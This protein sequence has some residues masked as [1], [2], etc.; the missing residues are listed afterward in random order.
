MLK[1]WLFALAC[2]TFSLI[3]H[4]DDK[5]TLMLDWYI[6]PNHVPIIVAQQ[7]G[8]FKAQHLDVKIIE[9]S[10]A[11][12]PPKLVAAGKIDLAIDYQQGLLMH[13]EQQMPISRIGT[14]IASPLNTILV[15]K[16]SG[17]N[18]I[19]DLKGKSVGYSVA[20]VDD[21]TMAVILHSAGLTLKDI[22]M[23]NVNWALVQA[24]LSKKVDAVTGGY[25]NVEQI[26]IEDKGV[27]VNAFYTEEHGIPFHDELI[28]VARN[29]ERE[30]DKFRRF[31]DA[32]REA[33]QFTINHP[34]A[35]WKIY[36]DYK[37]GLATPL[38]HKEFL[39]TIPRYALRPAAFD[40]TEYQHYA[41]F[42]HKLGLIKTIPPVDT[43]A[44]AP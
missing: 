44:F 22:K 17:I 43:Y 4:A 7:K 38:T 26:E 30:A 14:L 3:A 16:D 15:R 8:Y 39:A 5:L 34:E 23:V 36:G 29:N 2:G 1:K 12:V 10:D 25:R 11:S 6:N 19:A 24:L 28:F 40:K 37:N 33:T 35:A 42:M 13:A 21:A 41:E 32:I 27:A 20:G 18:S 9:P 31:D